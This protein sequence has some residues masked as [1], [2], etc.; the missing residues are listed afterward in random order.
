VRH[1]EKRFN[2]V[3]SCVDMALLSCL[4]P[5]DF[6]HLTCRHLMSTLFLYIFGGQ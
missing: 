3:V 5:E 4:I 6:L 2:E 1:D